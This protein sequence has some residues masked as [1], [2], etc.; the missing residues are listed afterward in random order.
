MNEITRFSPTRLKS[1]VKEVRKIGVFQGMPISR[2]DDIYGIVAERLG[3][4]ADTVRRWT[5]K[6]AKGPRDIN[7][8]IEMEKMFA[9]F[10]LREPEE[11]ESELMQ[12]GKTWNGNVPDIRSGC[13]LKAYSRMRRYI[14]S[15]EPENEEIFIEFYDDMEEMFITLPRSL[16][17]QLKEYIHEKFQPIVYNYKEVFKNDFSEEH[18]YWGDDGTFCIYEEN[19]EEHV[20]KILVSHI[21][22]MKEIQDEFEDFADKVIHPYLVKEDME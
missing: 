6:G 15:E 19:C 12:L 7:M 10:P 1:A 20:M 11:S 8:V 5:S 21:C 14:N 2:D 18:G 22:K 13:I 9:G 17:L 4:E 16:A 3:N